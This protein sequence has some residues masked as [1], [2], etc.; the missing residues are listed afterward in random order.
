MA[1]ALNRPRL[2]SGPRLIIRRGAPILWPTVWFPFLTFVTC[3]IALAAC[4]ILSPMTSAPLVSEESDSICRSSTAQA[5]SF[6][7]EMT[8]AM[9][10][11]MERMK[12][13]DPRSTDLTFADMMIAHHE[14][15]IAM[16][17]SHLRHGSNAELQRI[18]H[19]IIVEQR[20]EVAA[21]RHAAGYATEEQNPQSPRPETDRSSI[22]P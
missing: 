4:S 8:V 21:I 10:V 2:R 1:K 13:A 9:D 20:N 14:G 3:V 12:V 15:A 6:V 5:T 22:R 7:A 18:A 16:A 19:G 17:L 11:M